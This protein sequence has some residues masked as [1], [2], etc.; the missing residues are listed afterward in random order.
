MQ[1]SKRRR[2]SQQPRLPFVD[3]NQA[4]LWNRLSLEQQ[5]Q[6]RHLISQ[7]L[8]QIVNVQDNA[9]AAN[10]RSDRRE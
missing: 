8:Q 4:A 1:L 5:Q 10:E 3:E 9:G 6:C 7:M 2:Q